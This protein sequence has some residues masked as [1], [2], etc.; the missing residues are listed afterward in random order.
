MANPLRAGWK[1]WR[2]FGIIAAMSLVLC[3]AM[4]GMW[5]ASYWR[6]CAVQVGGDE[7][8]WLLLS[9][10]GRIHCIRYRGRIV[11]AN[12]DEQQWKS[13]KEWARSGDRVDREDN[14]MEWSWRPGWLGFRSSEPYP[15][16]GAVVRF[17]VVPWWFGV[18]VTGAIP[19]AWTV[20]RTRRLKVWRGLM[21]GAAALSVAVLAAAIVLG[22]RSYF[23]MDAVEIGLAS[24]YQG[25]E[26]L[27]IQ[28]ISA[29]GRL[30]VCFVNARPGLGGG[31]HYEIGLSQPL[32]SLATPGEG[33]RHRFLGFA[34][35][36][37]LYGTGG[38]WEETWEFVIPWYAVGVFSL[39]VPTVWYLRRCRKA[40]LVGCC[41]LCGYDLRA[42]PE[43]C[44]EC[45]TAAS[46][47]VVVRPLR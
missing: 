22:V 44:P 11:D 19:A 25:D 9:E 5:A 30:V 3:L 23:R 35:A 16:G 7:D 15:S 33:L 46:P 21:A 40:A 27:R 1:M 24:G 36:H 13:A 8:G 47:G 31:G 38:G 28:M 43:R 29:R 37:D 18:I 39:I 32:G 20:R 41:A 4:G 34:S 17:Y 2:V 14:A 45:G 10:R 12:G 26:W 6:T 42:T